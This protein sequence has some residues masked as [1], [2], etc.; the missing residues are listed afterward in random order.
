M[1]GSYG[2]CLGACALGLLLVSQDANAE[3][4]LRLQRASNPDRGVIPSEA[5]VRTR[6]TSN[7]PVE[8]FEGTLRYSQRHG[9]RLGKMPIRIDHDTA[10]SSTAQGQLPDPRSLHGKTV[11]VFG[12]ARS[13]SIRAT[14]VLDRSAG[15]GDRLPNL[16][17]N[18]YHEP[19][20]SDSRVGRDH[21][22]A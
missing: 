4:V 15:L 19:S 3:R 17:A 12:H 13:G 7:S 22:R 20:S 21:G 18:V 16:G 8:R 11:T 6:T 9:L 2:F 14:L 1:R 10:I 5:P